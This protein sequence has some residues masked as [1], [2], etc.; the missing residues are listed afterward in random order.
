M[1]ENFGTG[2]SRV[3]DAAQRQFTTVVWQQNRPPLD[4]ELNLM[5]QLDDDWRR[6]LALRGTPSGW[7]GNSVN[8][9]ESYVTS[10][11][12]S[13][14]FR[15]GQQRNGE[16]AA[17]Q[18]AVVNG[19][20]IPVTGTLTG[21][22]P[23]SPN[24]ADTWNRITLA[25]P[26]TNSGDSRIDFVFLEVWRVRLAPNP[27]TT[28]KPS[29][30]GVYRFGNVEGGYS[31][32]ADDLQDSKV[33]F[34]STQRIQVQYR[35]RVVTGLVGL[36][37]YPDGFDPTIVKARGAASA[38]TAFTY[39]NM[40]A[41]LGDPGLWRAGDGLP[42]ALGTVD[43]YTYAIPLCAVFRR[44]TVA[45]DGDPGQN[46]NGAFNRNP[47]AVDRT[48][49]K[50]FSTTPTLASSI[51]SAA[52]SLTLSSAT[53]IPLPLAPA[54]PVLIQIG[55][56][57]V[58]YSS[59]TGTTMTLSARGVLGSR[60]EAHP[61]G[62]A[63]RVSAARPD[64]LFADQIAKS[65]ILDLRHAVN[66]NGFDYGALLRTNLDKVLRGSLWGN[67]KRSGSGTQG[68]F[69][70]Y[71]DK[72]SNS[73]AALGVTKLDGPDNIRQI[74]SDAAVQHPVVFFA[75]PPTGQGTAQSISTAWGLSLTATINNSTG[76][77]GSFNPDDVISI[78]V[79]Q[80]K[81]GVAG[82]DA[83]QIRLLGSADSAQ[84]V[85]RIRVDGALQPLTQGT[86]YTVTANPGPS[87]NLEITLLNT[88]IPT[89]RRLEI[90]VH[91]LYGPG[92][93][94]SRRPDV[95]HSV[96]YL[97]SGSD[98]MTQLSGVPSDNVGLRVAWAPLW[99]KFR[100]Q[101]FSNLLPVT[102]EA[103]ADPG[104]RTI[105]LT[106]FR[107]IDLPDQI[108]ALDGTA[109]NPNTAAA[110]KVFG[111]ASG[112]VVIN[113]FT[114]T[115]GTKNFGTAGVVAGDTLVITAPA[116]LAGR[117]P[118]STT[119]GTTTLN[120]GTAGSAGGGEHTFSTTSTGVTYAIYSAQGIMPLLTKA[121][122]AKWATTDPLSLFSGTTD[123]TAAR[124]N[125]F[126]PVPRNLVPGWGEVRVPIIHSDPTTS[127]SGGTSTFD[128]GVNFGV[129]TKKGAGASKPNTEKNFVPYSNGALTYA[130]FTTADLSLLV[131]VSP[132]FSAVPFNAVSTFG[133][134]S[135]AGMRF[136][137]DTRGLG[138]EGL[139]L[140]PFYGVSRLFAVYEAEDYAKNGSAFDPSTRQPTGGGAVNLLR[141]DFSGPTFWIELDDDGDSTFILNAE[142]LDLSRSPLNTIASFAAGHYVIEA[143]IFGFD[144]GSWD[145]SQGFK[146]VLTRE[147]VAAQAASGTRS[148]NFGGGANALVDAPNL[149]VPGPALSSDEV[150]INYT[151][152]PYQGD[153]WGS[154]SAQQDIGHQPG[155]LL[156]G[157]L[158]Q[159]ASTTLDEQNLTRPNEKTFKVLASV[160]FQTTLGTGRIAG[161]AVL[162][163]VGDFRNVGWEDLL[164]SFP[165]SSGV[166]PRPAIYTGA[167]AEG[168]TRLSLGT[169]YHGCTERLPMG[170]LFRDKDFRGGN[171][172][173]AEDVEFKSGVQTGLVFVEGRAPGITASGVASS[174]DLE[175]VEI[176][177]HTVSQAS[178]QPGEILVHVDGEGGNYGV[179]TNFRVNRGGSLF[180]ASGPRPGGEFSSVLASAGS[181][182]AQPKVLSGVAMLVQNDVT[183]IGSTEVSAGGE[184]MMVIATSVRILPNEG[185]QPLMVRVGTNGSNEGYAAADIFRIEGHPIERDHVRATVD[186]S[187][188]PLSKGT[189]PA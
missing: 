177:V 43:G 31:F 151:R 88:F 83:D 173:G 143:S 5:Q 136:F 79:A 71:Q 23:G 107:R 52:L 155:P 154:Q 48:G 108:R 76:A 46:L 178:G 9:H 14:W 41:E 67:W 65:D 98:I 56:E 105:I 63:V 168:E 59:I 7:L 183:N 129:L 85:V 125:I 54:S 29:S 150:A 172:Y 152:T 147:R 181:H 185:S 11:T 175:Q 109:A 27:A 36:T 90:T 167:L 91:V 50:T 1:S 96:A 64:G 60:A 21:A 24:D 134:N 137:A 8:S 22:P 32:L 15:F 116:T 19:W 20:M 10:A 74:F 35:I 87:T 112:S 66:P 89:T 45:W 4:S 110:P 140:P 133:G 187:G 139:E 62:A 119:V 81:T 118:I 103:Y 158:F 179:L 101:T 44:N 58:Q 42:N 73:A 6:I 77:A 94:L 111:L 17:I 186:P 189:G 169:E 165:P 55:D 153:A 47:T 135:F 127:P 75:S 2:V 84:P 159:L 86:H 126:M 121:G 104:S 166:D 113:G 115:D 163:E 144:R 171:I 28:N 102:A 80:F 180:V 130:P 157:S 38:D 72:I 132:T 70:F 188:T 128:Q 26:P 174:S 68:P 122:T 61:A 34:E 164:A 124:K 12:W 120:I 69:I 131:P 184:L 114:L 92:R 156:T 99:S 49:F 3:L 30:S 149:V 53:N 93:G 97:S 138:R 95:L 82:A 160:G 182:P 13:N 100:S 33:G 145:L 117:Y 148:N 170:A 39:T 161:D 176:P 25:P 146:L 51:T 40:R 78:P 57:F 37:S 141:H 106:P 16:K 142:T 123:P 18:W 162:S